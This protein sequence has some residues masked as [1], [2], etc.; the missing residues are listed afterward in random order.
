VLGIPY[1][2]DD[3]RSP[4]FSGEL[5]MY[6]LRALHI[7]HGSGARVNVAMIPFGHP[8]FSQED[9]NY[10]GIQKSHVVQYSLANNELKTPYLSEISGILMPASGVKMPDKF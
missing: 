10:Y 5:L 6:K 7:T 2:L 8:F 3:F 4:Y 1:N 9:H